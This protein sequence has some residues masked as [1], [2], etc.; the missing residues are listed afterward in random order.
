MGVSFANDT[1][2]ASFS[3]VAFANMAVRLIRVNLAASRGKFM[4]NIYK[5]AERTIN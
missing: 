3:E 5:L 4:V 1:P 2:Y